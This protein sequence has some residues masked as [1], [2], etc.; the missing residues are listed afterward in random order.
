MDSALDSAVDFAVDCAVAH[1][2]IETDV[3]ETHGDAVTPELRR[4]NTRD[5]ENGKRNG[6]F[7]GPRVHGTTGGYQLPIQN[8]ESHLPVL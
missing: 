1:T 2:Q 4:R 3:F 7:H 6:N 5:T 8:L